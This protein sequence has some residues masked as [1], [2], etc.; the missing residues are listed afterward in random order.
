MVRLLTITDSLLLGTVIDR[1]NRFVV[2]VCFD[3]TPQRVFLGD[4][5][6]LTG[7][8]EP[9][10]SILCRAV[11]DPNRSTNYD[12]IAANVDG[13]YVSLRTTLANDLF[14]AAL[15]EQALPQFVGHRLHRREPPLPRHGRKD[16]LLV[17]Q[18]GA[19]CYVEVKSCTH[20]EDR[21]AKFPDR[22][23][24]RGRRHLR[25]LKQ[26]VNNDTN[27]TVVFVVQRPDVDRFR[28]YR[29]VDPEFADLLRDAQSCGVGISAMSTCF[30]PP[31]YRLTCPDLQIELA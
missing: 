10:R 8:I 12:A 17:G 27:A 23:T 30:E 2:R 29:S 28:P 26:L 6:A 16:F 15:T 20:V 25:S 11:T 14:A 1:P 31:Q 5:G 9:N 4:P 24:E 13:V 3:G 19:D 22:Q 21:T 18:D 7:I